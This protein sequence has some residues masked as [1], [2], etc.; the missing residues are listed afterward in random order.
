[1]RRKGDLQL[2]NSSILLQLPQEQK[3]RADLNA[4]QKLT[5]A[6][7]AQLQEDSAKSQQLTEQVEAL[8]KELD[9]KDEALHEAREQVDFWCTYSC[10]MCALGA[11]TASQHVCRDNEGAW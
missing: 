3:L 6:Q 4:Q 8:K 1:M 10:C 9:I 7:L 2:K 5:I 11:V